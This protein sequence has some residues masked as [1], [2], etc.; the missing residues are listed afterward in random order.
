M[1]LIKVRPLIVFASKEEVREDKLVFNHLETGIG[2]VNS[3]LSLQRYLSSF[4]FGRFVRNIP[5]VV[6]VGT[7][8]SS[9]KLD[10][11]TL[12]AP[13]RIINLDFSGDLFE[14]QDIL[15]NPFILGALNKEISQFIP[16]ELRICNFSEYKEHSK[17]STIYSSDLFVNKQNFKLDI[18]NRITK[19]AGFFDMES[20]SLAKVCTDFKVPFMS[21]KAVSDFA[22]IFCDNWEERANFLRDK[23][24]AV[25]NT[26]SQLI[27][28]YF[29]DF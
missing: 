15:F 25:A 23:L 21:I 22:D 3:A 16:E 5:L 9:L 27:S 29:E 10:V 6:N 19:E 4:D 7:C 24:T 8:G 1:K 12:V 28:S 17:V 2:R 26:Y 11:G 13:S 18:Y 20:A 14:E